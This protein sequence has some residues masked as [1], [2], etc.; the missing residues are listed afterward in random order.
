MVKPHM[1]TPWFVRIVLFSSLALGS[2]SHAQGVIV[3]G[4]G[5]NSCGEWLEE[6]QSSGLRAHYRSWVHGFLSGANWYSSTTQAK[7]PDTE[8]PMAFLDE[9]CKR[10]PLHFVVA[11]AAALVQE[12]GGPK[13]LHEWKR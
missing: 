6:A 9:Y 13:A 8:A 11:G 2:S 7:V 3:G 12:S 10:N 5:I 1:Q 4:M